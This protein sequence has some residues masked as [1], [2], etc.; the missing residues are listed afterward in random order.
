MNRTLRKIHKWTGI[1][2]FLLFFIQGITGVIITNKTSLAVTLPDTPDH[3]TV[4]LDHMIRDITALYPSDQL[5]RIIYPRDKTHP[6]IIRVRPKDGLGLY[7][8]YMNRKSG[9]ILS[10]GP[11]W[12][13]PGQL[14]EQLHVSLL[15]GLTGYVI[16]LAEGLILTFMA[17]SGL[18]IWWPR[19]GKIFSALKIKNNMGIKKLIRDLHVIPAV[20]FTPLII[21]SALT[22]TFIIAEPL[23]KPLISY[24]TP[25]SPD[26]SLNLAKMDKPAVLT[27]WQESMMI[28][29]NH[30]EDGSIA[31]LRFPMGTRI[32][33]AVIHAGRPINP[34]A[35]HLGAIDRHT[36]EM[37]VLTDANKALTGDEILEWFLPIHSGQIWG[38][39]RV[40]L[41]S[42]LGLLLAGLSISGLIIW[43][44][45]RPAQTTK[46]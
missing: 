31:Q 34:R 30:F 26:I 44:Q 23:L 39:F 28:L 37:T 1:I 12:H 45:R 6:L 18:I 10:H 43:W 33:G 25:V 27:S 8:I 35:Y 20:I 15:S 3:R 40:I 4:P 11:L 46:R 24:F 14:A 16:I 2:L 38:P 9:D 17:I 22:G 19:S 41:Q 5:D 32:L 29:E 21:L 7:I 36:G 13:Y 42:L